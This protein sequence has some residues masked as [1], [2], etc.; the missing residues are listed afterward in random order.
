VGAAPAAKPAAPEK[1]AE[2]GD[3]RSPMEKLL[4]KFR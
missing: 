4:D 1:P 2:T 3:A